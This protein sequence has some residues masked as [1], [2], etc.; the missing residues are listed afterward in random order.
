MYHN[1]VLICFEGK[2]SKK[3]WYRHRIWNCQKN[4]PKEE[5]TTSYRYLRQLYL[6]D[7]ERE[8]LSLLSRERDLLLFLLAS[9]LS[10]ERERD[11]EPLRDRRR[12]GGS[13][14]ERDLPDLERERR[15]LDRDLRTKFAIILC[16]GGS[17]TILVQVRTDIS[18]LEILLFFLHNVVIKRENFMI[19]S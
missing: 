5:G 17:G 3:H 11:L 12:R 8:R 1:I 10:R 18:R 14:R 13:E 16:C 4:L 19:I 7:P 15:D 6:R 2:V 9:L